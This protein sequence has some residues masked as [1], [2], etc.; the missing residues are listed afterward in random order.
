[1]SQ[2]YYNFD[3]FVQD[4]ED[5]QKKQIELQ[6]RHIELER[7]SKNRDLDRLYREHHLSKTYVG[8]KND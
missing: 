1:M 3:K 5:R 2:E 7:S 8:D 4:L 6:Q